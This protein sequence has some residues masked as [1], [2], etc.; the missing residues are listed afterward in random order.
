[1]T[2]EW[3]YIYNYQEK[4]EQLYHIKSDPL[5]QNNLVDKEV[6]HRNKLRDNLFKWV[7]TSRQYPT[8]KQPFQFS[9]EEKEKLKELGYI[10]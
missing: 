7:S 9:P 4:T 8:K 6:K 3:K 1:M 10:Q 5:E 2:S